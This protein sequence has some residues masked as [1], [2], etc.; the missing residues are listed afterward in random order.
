MK[1]YNNEKA[2]ISMTSWTKRI[3]TCSKTIYSLLK[4]C[5]GFHIVLVLNTV[6]FPEKENSLPDDL[7]TLIENDLIEVIWLDK[8]YKVFQKILFTM[9]KYRDVPII[10]ADDDCLYTSNYAEELYKLW[11]QNKK[12]I[13]ITKG[14]E[15]YFNTYHTM[16]Q[17]TLHPPYCYGKYGLACLNDK[18]IARKQ[19]DDYYMVLRHK[20]GISDTMI[21]DKHYLQYIKPH[22]ENDGLCQIYLRGN[23]IQETIR[24]YEEEIK[25]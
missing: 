23:Y 22:D 25:I 1:T 16:G 2:I 18:I 9:D 7:R 3:N 21:T 4:N 14:N 8:D 15:K 20:L 24:I 17:T 6:E 5:Q 19:D 10:G 12:A 13:C 11:E